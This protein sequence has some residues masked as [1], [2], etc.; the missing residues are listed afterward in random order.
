VRLFR[1]A[2]RRSLSFVPWSERKRV[3]VALRGIYTADSEATA[4]DRLEAFDAQWGAKY[5]MITRSLGSA[6]GCPCPSLS[7]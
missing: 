2:N 3:A 4:H 1:E 7:L 5:P 6:P